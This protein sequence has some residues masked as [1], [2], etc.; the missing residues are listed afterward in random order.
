[1]EV[2]SLARLARK[3]LGA[4][5][6]EGGTLAPGM[7]LRLEVTL[8]AACLRGQRPESESLSWLCCLSMWIKALLVTMRFLETQIGSSWIWSD[9]K[10]SGLLPLVVLALSGPEEA[11]WWVL[12][13]L[14]RYSF[15]ESV[16]ISWKDWS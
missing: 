15:V 12:S 11:L 13:Q 9:W 6:Q 14:L 7:S 5:M 10:C 3:L 16:E 2:L 1:M 4:H 8:L